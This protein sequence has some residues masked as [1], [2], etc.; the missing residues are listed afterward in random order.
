[1]QNSIILAYVFPLSKTSC[2]S[3]FKG[4]CFWLNRNG[5][6]ERITNPMFGNQRKIIAV[7]PEWI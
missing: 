6:L 7:I 2:Y 1:M 3:M 4:K 5:Q